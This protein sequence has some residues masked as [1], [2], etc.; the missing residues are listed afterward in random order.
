MAMSRLSVGSIVCGVMLG[1]T[2][3]KGDTN[4][5]QGLITGADG[6]P[7]PHAE[8]R[9]DRTDAPGKRVVTKTDANGNY[10]FAA[11]P[12]GKY[13]ITVV[14]E[15]GGPSATGATATVSSTDG[16]PIRRFISAM[17]YQVKADFRG[18]VR[19]NPRSQYVW[20]PGETGSHIAGRWVK[21]SE[22]KDPSADPLQKLPNT[23]MSTVPSLRINSLK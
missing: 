5:V 19:A 21:V 13:S 14:T 22:L 8:V 12:A 10:K 23:D 11:L 20:K 2:P 18:R 7:V 17:P 15:G 4:S 6:K 9:A 3:V 1:L 16:Q